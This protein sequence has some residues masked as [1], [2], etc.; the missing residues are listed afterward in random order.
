VACIKQKR[1]GDRVDTDATL[2]QYFR[3]TI[4][5]GLSEFKMEL[6][7]VEDCS[8]SGGSTMADEAG[9]HIFSTP[10]Y[11]SGHGT[12]KSMKI[13]DALQAVMAERCGCN[14]IVSNDSDFARAQFKSIRHV[15]IKE[16]YRC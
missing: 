11:H 2:C 3:D 14:Y 6:I 10:A 12:G 1:A 16:E 5:D 4:L 8:P 9:D 15:S 13:F 7:E